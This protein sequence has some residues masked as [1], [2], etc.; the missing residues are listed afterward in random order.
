MGKVFIENGTTK[1]ISSP[2][3]SVDDVLS[4]YIL[5][6]NVTKS[7]IGNKEIVNAIF[8]DIHAEATSEKMAFTH[9]VDGRVSAV[10]GTHTHIPT[11][12]ACIFSGGT[13][14][15]SDAGM[16]GDYNSSIGMTVKSSLNLFFD[17]DPSIHLTVADGDI[18]L[19]GVIIDIDNKTGLSTYINNFILSSRLKSTH[20]I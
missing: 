13:A 8:I 20:C 3:Q 11:A 19:C 5:P 4:K 1:K 12:D 10:I 2:F 17:R 15:Q 9:Y 18:S 7:S 14:Y 16:C 6:I